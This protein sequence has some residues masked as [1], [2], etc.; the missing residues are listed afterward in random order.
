MICFFEIR[1]GEKFRIFPRSFPRLSTIN[2][3][4]DIDEDW[5]WIFTKKERERDIIIFFFLFCD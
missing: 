5:N 1:D 4:L 3:Y 2:I